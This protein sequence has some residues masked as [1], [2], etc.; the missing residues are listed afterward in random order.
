[1]AIEKANVVIPRVTNEDMP[2]QN[3][4]IPITPLRARTV[5]ETPKRHIAR[6]K[7]MGASRNIDRYRPLN[8]AGQV[9]L[10]LYVSRVTVS[11]SEGVTC[12]QMSMPPNMFGSYPALG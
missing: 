12:G 3:S 2:V 4:P 10:G 6:R 1:M 8:T 11:R 9:L 5:P 7:R